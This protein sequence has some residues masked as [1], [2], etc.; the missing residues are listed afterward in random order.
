MDHIG[1]DAPLRAV[2]Q[3]LDLAALVTLARGADAPDRTRPTRRR[4]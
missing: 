1:A 4:T 2:H 3:L